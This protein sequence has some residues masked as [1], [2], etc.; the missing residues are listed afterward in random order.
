MLGLGLVL[1]AAGTTLNL[2]STLAG[3]GFTAPEDVL[4]YLTQTSS[5]R[6]LVLLLIGALL[7]LASE[8]SEWPLVCALLAAALALWGVAGAGHGAVHGPAVRFV[9]AVHAGAMCGWIGGVTALLTLRGV[10]RDDAQRFTPIA[11]ACVTTLA[12]T[13][14]LATLEHTGRL[15]GVWE[16]PYGRVLIVKLGLVACTLLAALWV[17]RT[18]QRGRSPRV[19]LL[20][21]ATLLLAVL[22]ATAVLSSTPLPVHDMTQM[23]MQ[24]RRQRFDTPGRPVDAAQP[25]PGVTIHKA[26]GRSHLQ[27]SKPQPAT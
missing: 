10:T 18:F 12:V 19:H 8:V 27:S 22:G 3:L 21:E 23:D 2:W 5:G 15:W 13:G 25:G 16:S 14:T 11:T 4:A 6:A 20:L 9:H 24:G 17:R 7:L 1:V 26:E